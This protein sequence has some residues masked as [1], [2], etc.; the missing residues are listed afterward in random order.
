MPVNPVSFALGRGSAGSG[1]SDPRRFLGTAALGKALNPGPIVHPAQGFAQLANAALATRL[2]GQAQTAEDDRL[3]STQ[4]TLAAALK[5]ATQGA[6]V[7]PISAGVADDVSGAELA[8]GGGFQLPAVE[9]G[10]LDA[11]IE[12]LGS[13]PDT[14]GMGLDLQLSQLLKGEET[15]PLTFEQELELRTAGDLTF[16]QQL[17]LKE[18]GRKPETAPDQFEPVFGEDGKTVIGQRNTTTGRVFDDPR[19]PQAATG[20]LT[21]AQISNNAEIDAARQR[22][23]RLQSDLQPGETLQDRITALTQKTTNTGRVNSNFDPL[24]DR[25]LRKAMDRKVGEDAGFESFFNTL[26]VPTPTPD[27]GPTP[28]EPAPADQEFGFLDRLFGRNTTVGSA[29]AAPNGGPAGPRPRPPAAARG[30]S[31]SFEAMSAA[32]LEALIRSPEAENLSPEDLV[33]V[34]A[35]LNA[36]QNRRR[37]PR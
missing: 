16:D 2:L 30:A 26:Q 9:A 3:K 28:V 6:P 10:G 19:S 7:Q 5:S 11:L 32:D 8:P 15:P 4:N 12:T 17:E 29:P 24:L 34:E 1:Q 33:R 18:A 23:V 31:P 13:N 25:D 21:N 36:Q 35:A 14:A 27:P 37:L 22:V 20:N